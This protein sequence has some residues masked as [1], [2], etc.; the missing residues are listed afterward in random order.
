[1]KHLAE[2]VFV[3]LPKK[4]F[5][6]YVL[7]YEVIPTSFCINVSGNL[8][9]DFSTLISMKSMGVFSDDLV[10]LK[11]CEYSPDRFISFSLVDRVVFPSTESLNTFLERHYE[12]FD[13]NNL[14]CDVIDSSQENKLALKIETTYPK[15][16]SKLEFTNE[17]MFEDGVTLLVHRKSLVEKSNPDFRTNLLERSCNKQDLISFLLEVNGADK[18][19]IELAC[20]FFNICLNNG[21][22]AGWDPALI[23]QQIINN[24]PAEVQNSPKFKRWTS[25]VS[26]ILEGSD[27]NL[28][29]TDDGVTLLRAIILV[30]LN[31]TIESLGAI[32]E[33]MKENIGQEVFN[34]SE[35]FVSIRFGYSFL[36]STE[37]ENSSHFRSFIQDFRAGL[38][39]NSLS[40]LISSSKNSASAESAPK[41]NNDSKPQIDL[42]DDSSTEIKAPACISDESSSFDISKLDWLELSDRDLGNYKSYIIKNLKAKAGFELSLLCNNNLSTLSIWILDFTDEAKSKKYS[43]P[44][45]KNIIAVQPSLPHGVRFEI[46]EIGLIIQLPATWFDTPNLKQ[47]LKHLITLL[48]PLDIFLKSNK[49]CD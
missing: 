42:F 19:N 24:S 27:I 3:L 8:A 32:K 49:F 41:A 7:A 46:T 31:P 45:A 14:I 23:Y 38:L 39:N 5:S 34:L 29:F 26:S 11:L 6:R 37:R 25:I 20:T 48:K 18:E 10:A 21:V 16:V 15:D 13:I 47:D 43:G 22:D 9:V 17:M 2:E 35:A 28:K 12:N 33:Q 44:M 4:Y 36:S 30:L 1:M 40:E